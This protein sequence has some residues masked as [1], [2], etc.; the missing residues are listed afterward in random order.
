MS[1]HQLFVF[2]FVCACAAGAEPYRAEVEA[3]LLRSA[4]FFRERVSQQGT[5]LWQYSADLA[6]RE[7]EGKATTTQGWIQPPGTPSVGMAYL[8]AWEA[9]RNR[10]FLEAARETA[11]ALAGAQLR[12]GGWQHSVELDPARRKRIAYREGG[13]KSGGRNVTSFDD[14][15]TQSAVR[16][17]ARADAAHDFKDE[18]IHETVL[19]ALRCILKAQHPNG[20]WAQGYERFPEPDEFPILKAGFPKEWSRTYPR[21][22]QYWTYYTLNDNNLATLVDSLLEVSRIYAASDDAETAGL[23]RACRKAAERVGDFLILAQMP[24]PQPAWAQQYD[25]EMHPAW[26]R[27]FEPPGISGGESQGAMRALLTL[28][29]E[30]GDAKYLEP[31]PK[32]LDYLRKSRLP[33][34]RLARFYELESNRPL[35][36][37]R[38]YELTYDDSDVPT[39]YSFKVTDQ[40]DQIAREHQQVRNSSKAELARERTI[41]PPTREKVRRVLAALDERGAWVE[42]G[43]LRYHPNSSTTRIIRSATFVKNVRTLSDYLRR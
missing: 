32:A 21:G 36:F 10:Y 20:A 35:Y 18:K 27:K 26:A 3:G 43:K 25:K 15:T 23:A 9:T 37:T 12:S 2:A 29:R 42:P 13:A 19:Y 14:D 1:L 16:F 6:E 7:G 4:K 30:T 22:Q 31:I 24:E 11:Y 33:D 39:H 28:Y 41:D 8:D 38:D 17:L 5:Y 40:T 34:G